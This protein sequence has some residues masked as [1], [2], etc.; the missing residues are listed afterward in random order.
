MAHLLLLS[1]ANINANIRS[2]GSLHA[3]VLLALLPVASFIHL[4]T[5]VRSLLSDRLVHKSLDLVLK[6]L[7]IAAIV[8]IMMS[9]PVGN[10][11]YCFTPLIAYIADTPEQCLL[12]GIGPKASP[13]STATYKQFGDPFPHPS[14]MATITLHA[15]EAAREEADPDDFENFLKAAKHHSLNGVHEPF[16]RN[17]PLADPS[18]FFMPEILHLF[19]RLFWD[20]NLQWCIAALGSDEIDYRFS[21]IQTPIGYCSFE[22]GISRLKQV[23]GCDHCSA[24]RYI[25]GVIAGAVPPKFLA[26]ISALLNFRYLAQM[27]WFDDNTLANV[28]AALHTFHAN[29]AAIIAAGARQGSNGSLE[30]WEIPKL[31]LLQNV[32]TSIRSAGA[33][34]QWTADVTEHAHVTEIKQPARSGNNQD[35][36][37]QIA[38]HLDRSDKCFRFDIA[39]Q[40]ASMEQGRPEEESD[41][42]E[43]EHEPES[44]TLHA[45]HYYLPAHASV[46]YFEVADA[47]SVQNHS[48]PP[49][50]FASST[51]AFQLAV[52][53]SLRA[54]IDEASEIYGLPDLRLALNDYFSHV[55]RSMG[56]TEKMQIWF[57]V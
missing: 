27:P 8:G 25:I 32:V 28:E 56:T 51:T 30:H 37:T 16:F 14:R 35:Y 44:E 12:A 17:W 53:P 38:R 46:N 7:K 11:C 39:T 33:T 3:H 57:K 21:L 43:D 47:N 15:I 10:S 52:R 5:H 36:Y 45:I 9:D 54:S 1:L 31:E 55:N 29:K 40:F 18:K 34:M 49:N 6:P 19:H 22:E 13:V 42:Q 50:V 2:K 41:D 4:K 26:A 24:Q 20:H 48:V 23:T